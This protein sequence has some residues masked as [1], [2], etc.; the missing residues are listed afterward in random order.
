MAE[1]AW[2]ENLR[3]LESYRWSFDLQIYPAQV[4]LAC[5][6]IDTCPNIVFIVNHAGMFVD[7]NRP[8][9]WPAW[10]D[11]LQ[12]LAARPNCVIKLSG[13]AMFDH[14]WTVDSVRPYVLESIECFGV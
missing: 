9:G 12:S 8:Q 5:E 10:R 4:R 7:R 13:F 6:V 2:R 1:P 11:G 3:R 14:T